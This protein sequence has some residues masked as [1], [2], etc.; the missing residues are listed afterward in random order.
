M[1]VGERSF[2]KGSVQSIFKLRDGE[3]LR[4]TTAHYYTPSGV[5]I[6]GRGISPQVEVVMTA[7]EDA[8]LDRQTSRPDVAEPAEFQERFG[9]TPIE[10]RQLDAAL[11]VLRAARL[12]QK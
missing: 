8:K 1:V 9:F 2:G 6:H 11:D 5:L 7:D 10:D 12:C 3:G 4:L